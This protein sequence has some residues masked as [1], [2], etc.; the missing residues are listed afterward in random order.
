MAGVGYYR[1][2]YTVEML[3]RALSTRTEYGQAAPAYARRCS[4][5]GSVVRESARQV[6]DDGGPAVRREAT[7]TLAYH[8]SI[9]ETDRLVEQPGGRVWQIA[10]AFDPDGG[11]RKRLEV[12]LVSVD[13]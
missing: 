8:P 12:Q 4:V 13:P 7:V 3:D 2:L 5:R 10:G 9:V 6:S 11:R 1:K